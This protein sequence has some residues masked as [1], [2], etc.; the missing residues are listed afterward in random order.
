MCNVMVSYFKRNQKVQRNERQSIYEQADPSRWEK[1]DKSINR[2]SRVEQIRYGA[3]RL[4]QKE[5][6]GMIRLEQSRVK[7]SVEKRGRLQ[8]GN[9][10]T[11]I[12][13]SRDKREN[14]N[15]VIRSEQ[16]LKKVVRSRAK[17][18]V[19]YRTT[20]REENIR[21]EKVDKQRQRSIEEN[22]R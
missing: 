1:S 7:A 22:R 9:N 13:K 12:E 17:Q 5:L 6:R 15:V 3:S 18:S 8:Q 21:P 2:A 14:K 19:Q 20:Q 16:R 10:I 4:E 11:E